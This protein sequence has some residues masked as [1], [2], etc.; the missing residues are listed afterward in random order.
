MSGAKKNVRFYQ[1]MVLAVFLV[2]SVKTYSQSAIWHDNETLWQNALDLDPENG[3][4]YSN[5]GCHY[6]DNEE[7]EKAVPVLEKAVQ[8]E[9]TFNESHIAY[10]NLG[11][12]YAR[13]GRDEEAITNYSKAIS[14]NPGFVAAIFGRGLSYTN[15][16]K[17]DSAVADFTTILTKI[18]SLNARAF[19]SRGFAFNK[20]NKVDQALADYS[21]AIGIDPGY[22]APYVNRGNIYFKINLLD[23]ALADYNIALK[24]DP[25][26]GSTFL[27]RSSVYFRKSQFREALQDALKAREMKIA[28]H[29]NYI[30]DLQNIVSQQQ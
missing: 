14:K 1:I 22:G 24:L 13:L 25:E 4:A 12:A 9:K 10:Q 29:P 17:F 28:V 2:F 23:E 21:K 26:N 11:V 27:N 18:D 3:L 8:H 19:Y 30:S 6:I 7:N 16:G 5:L 20:W 15:V